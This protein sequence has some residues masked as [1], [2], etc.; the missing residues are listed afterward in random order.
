MFSHRNPLRFIGIGVLGFLASC[1][2]R[3]P[4]GPDAPVDPA[5]AAVGEQGADLEQGTG[6]FA[7]DGVV[8]M[9]CIN[10]FVFSHVRAPYTYRV[11][12]TPSGNVLYQDSFDHRVSNGTMTGLSSGIVWT[13]VN[14]RAPFIQNITLGGTVT[15]GVFNGDFVSDNGPTIKAH[16]VFHMRQDADG[17]IVAERGDFR[18]WVK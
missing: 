10:E 14:N 5:A 17:Q 8:W 6:V 12:V 7:F 4:A 1:S 16:E 15:H 13:R 9:D 11:T 3:T 18:C 2:D